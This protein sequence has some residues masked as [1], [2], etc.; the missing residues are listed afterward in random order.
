MRALAGCHIKRLRD[1]NRGV[2]AIEFAFISM[3]VV[4]ALANAGDF[5]LYIWRSAQVRNAAQVGA[6]S[7][8]T[9]C[10]KTNQLPATTNCSGLTSVVTASIQSTALGNRISLASGSPSEGYY[11]LAARGAK[12]GTL[13]PVGSLSSKPADCSS[14]G[15]ASAQ[16]GDYFIVTVTTPYAP[17]FG[18]LSVMSAWAPTSITA[19]SWVRLQ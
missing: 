6:Q 1:D 13:Q 4:G 19:T 10:A 12:A 16:P 14:V 17:I 9:T 15:S 7:A 8:W 5:G 3:I 18:G 2:A 11:C